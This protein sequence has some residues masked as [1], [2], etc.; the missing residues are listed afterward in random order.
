MKIKSTINLVP[1]IL[2]ATLFCE[3]ALAQTP[4]I[5]INITGR[6]TGADYIERGKTEE[7]PVNVTVGQTVRWTN[8]TSNGVTTSHT[9]S[10][11]RRDSNNNRIFN[12]GEI[13][14]DRIADVLMDRELFEQA[15]GQP[16]GQVELDYICTR[17]PS[18]MGSKIILTDSDGRRIGGTNQ[19]IRVRKEISSLTAVEI[20]SL[21][22]GIEVMKSRAVSNR[23][24]WQYWANIHGFPGLSSDPLWAQCE[25]STLHFLTWHRA[26]LY[27]F[28]LVLRE[29]SGDPN[30]ALPYWDWTNHRSLPLIYRQPNNT[31]TNSLFQPGRTMNNGSMLPSLI[32]VNGLN[33]AMANTRFLRF[34]RA[35]ENSPHDPI[36]GLVGGVMQRIATSAGDPIFWA[37]HSNIDRLWNRWLALGNT[38][39]TDPS[40]LNREFTFVG[41]DGRETTIQVAQ[42]LDHTALGY[43]YDDDPVPPIRVVQETDVLATST[44]MNDDP[45]TQLGYD[46]HTVSLDLPPAATSV[47]DEVSPTIETSD[48]IMINVVGIQYDQMPSYVYGIFLELPEEDIVDERRQLHY[49]GALSFFSATHRHSDGDADH[50]S[51]SPFDVSVDATTAIARL[52]A[53]GVEI[54]DH[55]DVTIRPIPLVPPPGQADDLEQS[56]RASAEAANVRFQRI[57][58]T[59]ER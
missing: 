47:L 48:R 3:L 51:S 37:H 20:A 38:N 16:G 53:A 4:E 54:G 13:E 18:Q 59:R 23:T 7:L 46:P 50:T 5:V 21:R 29:A 45:F 57:E 33:S 19:V 56:N 8:M 58:I 28:E 22:R 15:G 49:A 43:R 52:R 11:R 10:A 26:Y 9:A 1:L 30:L 12:T 36:H 35:L 17:H 14:Q 44:S 39:P 32:V 55:L 24:S 25:H 40:F 41:P 27:Y 6:G 42:L 2:F 34:S 31:S